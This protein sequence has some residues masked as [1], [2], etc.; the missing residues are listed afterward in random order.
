MIHLILALGLTDFVTFEINASLYK[1][2][3]L[4]RKAK[5][6][7]SPRSEPFGMTIPEAG[8]IP[9]WWFYRICT[10]AISL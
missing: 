10:T 4:M 7:F 1:L 8:L 6:C 5:V 9:A 2:L 3:D